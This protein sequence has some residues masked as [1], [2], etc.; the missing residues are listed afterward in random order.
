MPPGFLTWPQDAT[1]TRRIQ[2]CVRREI[3]HEPLGKKMRFVAGADAAFFGEH[4]VG[5]A[6]LFSYPGMIPLEDAHAVRQVSFPYRPGFLFFREGPDALR[7]LGTAPDLILC[8]GHG[9]AHPEGAGLASHIGVLMKVPTIGC[10]KSRLVGEYEEPGGGKGQSSPLL[11]REKPVGA[12]VRTQNRVKPLFVS[13]GHRITLDEAVQIVLRCAIRYRIPEPLRRA[14]ILS[15][16]IRKD[17]TRE[18]HD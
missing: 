8:D 1:H 12:V 11:F 15:R 7:A 14:D 13:P 6:S 18:T 9:I 16:R 17:L 5:A 4:V 2:E 10:A 3:R